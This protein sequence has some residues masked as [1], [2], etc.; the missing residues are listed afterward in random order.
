MDDFLVIDLSKVN[1]MDSL[2]VC[3]LISEVKPVDSFVIVD[4]FMHFL[5]Q[6]LKH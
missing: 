4:N 2:F 5:M 3:F 6:R 1:L